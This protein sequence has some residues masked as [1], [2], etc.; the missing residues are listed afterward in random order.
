M[1]KRAARTTRKNAGF[2]LTELLVTLLIVTLVTGIAATTIPPAWR[3]YTQVVDASNAQ[4]LLTT[5]SALLRDELDTALDL[6]QDGDTLTYTSSKTGLATRLMSGARS[7]DGSRLG[8]V[9]SDAHDNDPD[10]A[11]GTRGP[12]RLVSDATTTSGMFVAYGG[13]SYDEGAGVVRLTLDVLQDD[14]SAD[15][16]L[17]A[18]EEN[19]AYH[20][21]VPASLQMASGE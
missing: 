10:D 5:T 6:R 13:L 11:G 3:T 4:A 15:G 2:S 19:L 14:G 12:R 20:V 1:R 8:I 17:L 18:R 16:K 21:I 9:L 7:A